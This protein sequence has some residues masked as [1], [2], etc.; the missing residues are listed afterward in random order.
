MASQLSIG[1]VGL[2]NV[3]KSTL[4]NALLKKQVAL[5]ANY[6]FATIKPNIGVVEVPDERL[7]VLAE[8][9]QQ[10]EKL[11]NLPPIKHALVEFVDIAGLVKGASQGEGLGNQFLANIRETQAICHVLRAFED[12][13]VVREGSVSAIEDLATIRTELQ[14]A[15]LTTLNKQQ[16]PKGTVAKEDKV[17]WEIIENFKKIVEQGHNI[18]LSKTNINGGQLALGKAEL[19]EAEALVA[20]ELCL[21]TAK[22]EIFVINIDEEDLNKS[23]SL[24]QQWAQQLDLSTE[25]IVVISAK[26]ES[27]LAVLDSQDQTAYLEDLGLQESGLERLAAVA[28]QVLQLQSFLT[29]GEIEVKAWTIEKGATARRA[30]GVIHSDFYDRFISAKVIAFADF[31]ELGGWQKAKESGKIRQ[32]GRDYVMQDGDVVE[33][34]V[35]R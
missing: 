5:A 16:A 23:A 2:P 6:P 17:R 25:Q 20:K 21:L 14:L 28:Y 9:T 35:G 15:D 32:E 30:A 3:G 7:Q 19:S 4:F 8:I 26:I 18:L 10:S 27:Q 31:V 12:E 13:N 22:P 1:I 11:A 33:F 24:K 29:A 34:M